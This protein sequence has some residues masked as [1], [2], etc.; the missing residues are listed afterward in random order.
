MFV[1]SVAYLRTVSGIQQV[2]FQIDYSDPQLAGPLSAAASFRA[3]G[4]RSRAR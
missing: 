1:S 4:N 2:D 3:N